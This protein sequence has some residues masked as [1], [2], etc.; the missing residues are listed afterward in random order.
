[1]MTAKRS[2]QQKQDAI[3]RL[4]Y[5]VKML[6]RTAEYFSRE[7]D[8][9]QP[10]VV[11]N[12]LIH[13]FLLA[14]RNLYEFLFRNKNHKDTIHATELV[15]PDWNI[16]VPRFE[17]GV[18]WSKDEPKKMGTGKSSFYQILSQRLSHITWAR[19]DQSKLDWHEQEIIREFLKPIDRF[20]NALPDELKSDELA[21]EVRRLHE[22]C[23]L[24]DKE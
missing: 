7:P 18:H 5:E 13:S 6:S 3:D 23:K 22:T 1:M 8:S 19:V 10:W 14:V 12:S 11:H 17:E 9:K 15:G 21:E 20:Q 2:L 4:K 16:I 24:E